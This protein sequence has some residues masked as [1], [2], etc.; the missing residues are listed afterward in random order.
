M[1]YSALR[2]R[3]CAANKAIRRTGLA[4]LTWGNAGEADREAGVFAIKPSGVAYDALTP[5]AIVIVSLAT[6][7]TVE[8]ALNPSSDTPTLWWLFK[9]FQSVGGIVHTHSV[10]ATAWAQARRGIPVFGTTH[11][12]YFHGDVP[13]TR[14]LTEAE[15]ATD[16]EL[17]TGKVIV[18]HFEQNR[19]DPGQMPA[20]LVAGH[21]PF[22]WGAHAADAVENGI[23]LEEV[24]GMALN[25]LALNPAL[26]AVPP[27]L[28]DKHFL[29]KHGAGAYY[30]Q[31]AR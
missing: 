10:K 23:V 28:L 1:H 26:A 5:E 15:V 11:A 9:S 16:Y 8:G 20:V 31:G 22:V 30:G 4:I 14:A 27:Y 7:E 18:E 6:G 13:C 17:N 29:R 25:S 12:D 21:A 24:A 2:E 19:L 3:V